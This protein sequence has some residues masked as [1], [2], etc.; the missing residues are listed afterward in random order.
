MS[1]ARPSEVHDFK[2]I[3]SNSIDG[4]LPLLVGG[5]AVNLWAL[6]Y[7]EHIGTDLDRWLPL[8]S[9]DLDLFGRIALLDEMKKRFGG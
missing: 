2:G 5:H 4:C 9:K 3:L 6:I 7:L 1:A 8:T